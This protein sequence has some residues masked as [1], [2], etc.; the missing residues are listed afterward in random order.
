M[1]N[2]YE[3]G[4]LVKDI[5]NFSMEH[6]NDRLR[7]QKTVH[8]LQSFGI[9]VGYPYNWYVRGPYCPELTT[10]GFKLKDVIGNIPDIDVEFADKDYQTRYAKFKKFMQDK[11]DDPAQLEIAS[12]ICFLHN[13]TDADKDTVLRLTEGKMESFTMDECK[14]IWDELEM[15]GVIK[16]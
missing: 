8:L 4:L 16:T 13:E 6:F 7:F 15:H 5:G 11:K 9:D 14:R 1:V 3:L 10:V 2:V 12:S